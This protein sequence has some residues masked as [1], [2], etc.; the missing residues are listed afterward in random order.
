M[1]RQVQYVFSDPAGGI[2]TINCT[3]AQYELEENVLNNMSPENTVGVL[4]REI[5]KFLASGYRFSN[6]HV[7][8]PPVEECED[9][10]AVTVFGWQ[11]VKIVT[12]KRDDLSDPH[13]PC[14]TFKDLVVGSTFAWHPDCAAHHF[15][16]RFKKIE[17]AACEPLEGGY[18]AHDLLAA[19]VAGKV[20]NVEPPSEEDLKNHQHGP[21]D[22]SWW[23]RDGNGIVLCRVCD[24][25]RA[26]KLSR[27]RPEILRPYGQGDVD[28]SIEAEE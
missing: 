19:G 18:A 9:C 3:C 5:D 28:E 23:E 12:F 26:A 14:K 25:C 13:G 8:T 16:G 4:R 22:G 1:N 2:A 27:Y 11:P 7:I 21:D 17:A 24:D 6:W 20:I 15:P 10:I